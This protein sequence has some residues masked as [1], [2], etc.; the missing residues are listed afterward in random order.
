AIAAAAPARVAVDGRTAAGK[1][2]L[3]EELAE[4]LREVA[5]VSADDFHRPA[6]ERY[7]RGR[8]SP[9]GYYLDT[10]DEAALRAS[11][12]DAAAAV[13]LVDGIFL[14]RRELDDLW[15][16]RIWVEIVAAESM[17]RGLARDGDDE[18]G[19]RLYERRHLPAEA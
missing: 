18:T 7:A 2:I 8:E 16:L 5:R 17:R 4:R 6:A 15:D 14:L 13:V 9:E 11:V 1:S 12:L 3:A 19:R 10:F